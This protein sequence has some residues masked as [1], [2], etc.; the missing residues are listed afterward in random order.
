VETLGEMTWVRDHGATLAQGW[1]I[2]KPANPPIR[3]TPT[4][5]D[6]STAMLA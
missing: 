3:D 4:R 5:T 1:F 2:A 6:D